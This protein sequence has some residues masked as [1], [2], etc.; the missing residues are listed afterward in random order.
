ST[1]LAIA[2]PL[3]GPT[4][5]GL[6]LEANRLLANQTINLVVGGTLSHPSVSV[7]AAP[8]LGEEAVRFFL[9]Q[10]PGSAAVP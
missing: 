4:P 10:V 2:I 7:Q 5:V 6:L 9:L 8:L 1:A 3:A